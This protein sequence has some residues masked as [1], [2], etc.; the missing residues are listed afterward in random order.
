MPKLRVK[1]FSATKSEDRQNL[2]DKIN[3]WLGRSNINVLDKVVCQSSD[4]QYHCLSVV[5]FYEELSG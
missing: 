2:G 5:F 1:T 4:S 3:D